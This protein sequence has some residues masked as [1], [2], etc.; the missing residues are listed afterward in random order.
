MDYLELASRVVQRL[1]DLNSQSSADG[2]TASDTAAPLEQMLGTVLQAMPHTQGL[3]T[4]LQEKPEDE[5]RQEMMRRALAEALTNDPDQAEQ[6]SAFLSENDAPTGVAGQ[7]HSPSSVTVSDSTVTKSDIAGRDIDK[8]RTVKIVFGGLGALLLL[9]VVLFSYRLGAHSAEAAGPAPGTRT[10]KAVASPTELD[11]PNP[12]TVGTESG[13]PGAREAMYAY[14]A[15]VSQGD[16]YL[17]CDFLATNF[18][19]KTYMPDEFSKMSPEILRMWGQ[20]RV[21]GAWH[22]EEFNMSP[23]GGEDRPCSADSTRCLLVLSAPDRS[24]GS[25]VVQRD[26]S[27]GRWLVVLEEINPPGE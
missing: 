12:A 7:E 15:A 23:G 21:T 19:C 27:L 26:E 9:A 1:I 5:N 8:S 4:A 25:A 13:E 6:F 10:P 11:A 16:S 20:A 3:L 22:D 14:M 2:D 17:A 18:P 24:D